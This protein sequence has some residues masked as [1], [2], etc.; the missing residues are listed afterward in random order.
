MRALHLDFQRAHRPWSWLG[1]AVLLAGIAA[2]GLAG[3]D[4]QVVSGQMQAWE[5]RADRLARESARRAPPAAALSDAA[6]RKQVL[7]VQQANI[8]VR[9]LA[10]PWAALFRAVDASGANGIALL[11][12]E[13]DTRKATV[14]ISGEAK[15]LEALLAYVTELARQ[16]AFG[17]VLLQGHQVQREVPEHPLRFSVLAQWKR[18]AP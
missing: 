13:P 10:V 8:V 6:A 9:E 11:A 7:E 4:Y 18:T 5:L 12:L 3:Y 16:E 17:A 2:L 14:K 1:A 15:D